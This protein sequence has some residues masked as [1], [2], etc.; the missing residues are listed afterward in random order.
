MAG[1]KFGKAFSVESIKGVKEISVGAGLLN[2]SSKA[3]ALENTKTELYPI[4]N[5]QNNE[6]NGLNLDKVQWLKQNIEQVGL[7]HALLIFQMEDGTVKL[8]SG[9]Q[10]LTAIKELKQEGKLDEMVK[11]GVWADPE[12]VEVKFYDLEKMN[13]PTGLS[14]NTRIDLALNSANIHRSETD[15]DKLVEFK[16]WKGIYE[17]LRKNGVEVFEYGVAGSDVKKQQV[18]KGEKTRNLIAEQM[19]MSPAQVAKISAIDKK[20]SIELI[21]A[22]MNNEVDIALGNELAQMPEEK[23]EKIIKAVK[24]TKNAGE[25]ITKDDVLFYEHREKE[26]SK[27]ESFDSSIDNNSVSDETYYITLNDFRRGLKEVQ[28]ALK[29]DEQGIKVSQIQYKKYLRAL[30]NIEDVICN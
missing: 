28:R 30:K 16:R 27:P 11:K 4:D 7:L 3:I 12:L 22:V 20:G 23:Q 17:E 21:D 6:R 18:I 19:G 10:R 26:Q 24:E 5:I 9:E 29:K 8:L 13:I 25:K 15:A 1:K 2:E 14:E